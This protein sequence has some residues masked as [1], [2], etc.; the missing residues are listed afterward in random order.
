MSD[1]LY[2][3]GK[4]NSLVADTYEDDTITCEKCGRAMTPLHID[5]DEWNE[6]NNEEKHAMLVKYGEPQI[7][8]RKS[9]VVHGNGDRVKSA[10][11]SGYNSADTE[12]DYYGRTSA[13]SVAA[14]VF[15]LLGCLGLVGVI[16]G[17]V[18][19]TRGDGRKKG[20]S[21]AA[22]AI[23]AIMLIGS[24]SYV[25]SADNLGEDSKKNISTESIK[26]DPSMSDSDEISVDG[27]VDI[28]DKTKNEIVSNDD[29]ASET[30]TIEEQVLVEQEGVKITAVE[31]VQGGLFG[32]G[33]KLLV[34][35]NTSQNLT[36][37]CDALIVNDYMLT[38]LFACSIA[39]GKQAYETLDLYTSELKKAGINNV[40][41]IEAYFRVYDSDSWDN[42]FKTECITIKTSNYDTMD[43]SSDINGTELVNQDGVR[44]VG[45]YVDESSFWGAAVLLYIENNA[46]K[47][48]T[49]SV[50][51][52][53]VNGFMVTPYFSST[54]YSGKKSFDDITLM[55]SE[56]E[57]SGITSVDDIELSFKV[58]NPDTYE[59]LFETE[60]IMFKTKK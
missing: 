40:G 43:T 29:S 31:Y 15:S 11:K 2:Y 7:Q 54:V 44:I 24:I 4:C 48:V 51:N 5:E 23:G 38:D 25:A 49:I 35:N 26:T 59:T 18:D 60:P 45:Q 8:K 16:L 27:S 21:I 10:S 13:M 30:A 55:S 53:S 20:L 34:E 3:C 33:I 28:S 56:L 19:I 37:G 12:K 1:Y 36:V 57:E 42:L 32:D 50:D 47:N 17:I 52:M 9:T 39:A 41:L 58:Y 46:D 22:I 14:F 6:M